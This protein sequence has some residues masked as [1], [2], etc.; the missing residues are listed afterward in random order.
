MKVMKAKVVPVQI[1][2]QT[3][4]QAEVRSAA[5]QPGT[6]VITTRPDALQDNSPV[7]ITQPGGRGARRAQ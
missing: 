7:A 5:I 6:T 4:T 2:L 1:G 3:D